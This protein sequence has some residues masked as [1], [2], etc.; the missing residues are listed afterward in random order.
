LLAAVPPGLICAQDIA[1]DWQGTLKAGGAELR[2]V[3]HI[4]KDGAGFKA[5]L[6]SV[7]QGANGIPVTSILLQD[8]TLKLEIAAVGGS[9][10]G[11]V[12]A[13]ASL[14]Q[15]AL[16]QNG[17]S[18]PLDFKRRIVPLKTEHKPA[19]P[20]D[21][22]GAWQGNLDMGALKVRAIV[23]F[24][25]TEDGLTATLDLP[26]Q[27]TVGLPAASVVREGSSIKVEVKGIGGHFDGKFSSDLKTL[28]GTWSQGGETKP[29][30][31]QR[32]TD[33]AQLERRRPQN[34]VKP[35]PYSD[36]DVTYENKVANIKLAATL[37]IPRGKGPFPAVLLITGSGPQDRDESLLGHKPFLVL[38][39]YLTRHGIAVLRADDRGTAKSG[40][41][42]GT[43]TT[44]DFATDAEAGVAYLKT[45]SEVNPH[46]IGL[47]GHSEGGVIAPMVAARNPDVAFIVM[48]A[49]TGVSG[50]EILIA[51]R[52]LI[53][54][55]AGDS[56]EKLEK[57]DA[58]QRAILTLVEREKD[59]AVLEKK[60]RELLAG[61]VPE[62]QIG[63]QIKAISTPWFRYFLTYDPAAA[64]GKLRC[65]V[66]VLN[67][68]KDLQV[69]PNL[70]LPAIRKALVAGGNKDF[71]I[72]E[73]PGLNHLFQSAKTG[74]PTEYAEIEETIAPVALEKMASWIAKH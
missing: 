6:D 52:R 28:D 46:K 49:G 71:E 20:S 10:E 56:R 62:A 66:L 70:N 7:D 14:I 32:L 21:V 9:Y 29:L 65:P 13:D 34:P 51:Q 54:E 2:V 22:D 16:S 53:A 73:L 30:V 68:E 43:A 57:G 61:S 4:A 17:A 67:G 23:H 8:A 59:D 39:D 38:S 41:V 24:V 42:F 1:G 33:V 55:A 18:L 5:K 45:R 25:N 15:G 35:Y 37:T 27:N 58:Q 12:N 36:E 74:A 11:K 40:G 44:A 72:D 64:L 31:F 60:V 63:P 3:L 69:P 47:I 48:M 50:D 26:D 19:N